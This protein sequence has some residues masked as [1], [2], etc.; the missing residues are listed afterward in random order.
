MP[1]SLP[2]ARAAQRGAA[3]SHN[4]GQH[5]CWPLLLRRILPAPTEP[6]GR[7]LGGVSVGLRAGP[8]ALVGDAGAAQRQR[9]VLGLKAHRA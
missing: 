6:A 5:L 7:G 3:P 9:L 4:K 2:H 8:E 1:R